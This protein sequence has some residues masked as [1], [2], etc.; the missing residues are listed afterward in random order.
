MSRVFSGWA[1]ALALPFFLSGCLMVNASG[2]FGPK[3]DPAVIAKI[4]PGETSKRE[5]LA[6]LGPPEE[7]LRSEVVESLADETTRVSGAISL[8]N[9]AQNA[10]SWQRDQLLG[11]G[12]V[13]LVY[14]RFV[15]EVQS[16]VLVVFFDE[17]DRVREVSFRGGDVK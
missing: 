3:L 6:L 17:E 1:F 11:Q 10:F 9:R 2:S 14:N 7:F 13:L 8:G 15:A 12:N 5:V 16:D 4:V